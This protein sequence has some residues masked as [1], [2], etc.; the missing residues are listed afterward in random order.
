[1]KNKLIKLL[2]QIFA[3]RTTIYINDTKVPKMPKWAIKQMEEMQKYMDEVIGEI[4]E[5]D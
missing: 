4:K 5:Y 1:M 3:P 2:R